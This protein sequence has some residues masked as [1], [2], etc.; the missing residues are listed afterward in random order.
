MYENKT[1]ETILNTMLDRVPPDIDKREGS[2][3]Y[4][5]LAPAASELCQMYID[6]DT[7][8]NE[9]FADTA[10][11]EY[12]IRRAKERGI[13]PYEATKAIGKAV[14]NLSVPIGG[15]FNLNQFNYSVEEVISPQDFSYK[16]ICETEGSQANHNLG[17]LIP[18]D[19]IKGLT[20]AEL[21]EVL[22][23]GEDAE[24]TEGLRKRYLNSFDK[25]AFGGNRAD[26]LEKINAISGVGGC[27]I[28][29]AW[30]GG[31]TVK[32]VV[33]D[34][35][36]RKPTQSLIGDVQTAVDPTQNAGEGLGIAPIDHVVTIDGVGETKIDISTTIT[37]ESG[38]SFAECQPYIQ[39]I[40]DSYFLELSRVWAESN[41]IV[42]R[43]SQIES[44]LLDM[45]GILDIENTTINLE[46]KNLMLQEDC[47]PI[48]GDFHG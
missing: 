16:V 17:T 28:Y 9:T 19:F 34:S 15:R 12:L 27:K 40:L 20:K 23:P 24:S 32:C 11:R 31:G 26:Y 5:A 18:I 45:N 44:R 38:W 21:V 7:V 22:T 13:T 8:L 47:I 10:S 36:Y 30:N 3:I 46:Q 39:E 42:V 41:N 33:I 1:F 14:F 48:R 25:Q 6:L 4:D 29:R 2:I 37:Y 43:I 35:E